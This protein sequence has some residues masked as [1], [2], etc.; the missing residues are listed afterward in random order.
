MAEAESGAARREGSAGRLG[1]ARLLD[2]ALDEVLEVGIDRLTMTGVAR[3][4]GVTTG[5]LYPRF[6]A[7]S[8]L[9]VRLWQERA[10]P[11]LAA[12]LDDALAE[13]IAGAMPMTAARLVDP[14]PALVAAT[15]ALVVGARDRALGEVVTQDLTDWFARHGA[16]LG[17][18]DAAGGPD[19]DAVTVGLVAIASLVLGP[20][21]IALTGEVPRIDWEQGLA[22]FAV[23]QL[24]HPQGPSR[25]PVPPADLA[26][27][28][29]STDDA[30]GDA[31]RT[32]AVAVVVEVGF[33]DATVARIARRAAYSTQA[34]Y[35]R[36]ASKTDLLVEVA[37]GVVFP[38][39]ELVGEANLDAFLSADPGGGLA[40]VAARYVSPDWASWRRLRLETQL[41]A[42][43]EPRVAEVFR[44]EHERSAREWTA[45]A[46]ERLGPVVT[47][48]EVLPWLSRAGSLGLYLLDPHVRGLADLDW[49][50]AFGAAVDGIAARAAAAATGAADAGG[51][52]PVSA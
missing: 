8:E 5:A 19:A 14:G 37:R 29:A 16:R 44:T 13:A 7:R 49:R 48:L 46:R 28:I 3:R 2:A 43:H 11:A 40:A 27:A 9:V 17:A 51:A 26:F 39:M 32:A 41:A 50:L 24:A 20:L 35:L 6:E 10:W 23:A 12:H 30:L 38:L 4:A 18:G 52:E 33:E 42:R 36:H 1:E 45:E 47:L 22:C 34:L 15:E 21:A 25:G 31:L